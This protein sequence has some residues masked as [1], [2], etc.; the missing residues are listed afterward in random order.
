MSRLSPRTNRTPCVPHPIL[1]GRTASHTAAGRGSR[2]SWDAAEG[3]AGAVES[4]CEP[5]PP[6]SLPYKVD[7]S[8]P[9]LRTNWTRQR[10]G[11]NHPAVRGTDGTSG[12][13]SASAHE[14]PR[15]RPGKARPTPKPA[16]QSQAPP[17]GAPHIASAWVPSARL[18][19]PFEPFGGASASIP[20]RGAAPSPRATRS[21]APSAPSIR[22]P[23][24]I[25]GSCGAACPISTG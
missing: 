21:A 12:G 14:A 11:L 9:S 17:G 20:T 10:R 13:A 19:S 15:N 25:A 2:P 6:P 23:G 5:P 1:I 24:T 3:P 7:T 18:A 8:L 16:R 22:V 4:R